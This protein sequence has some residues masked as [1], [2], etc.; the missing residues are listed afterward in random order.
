MHTVKEFFAAEI[1]QID[2]SIQQMQEAIDGSLPENKQCAYQRALL[3][4]KHRQRHL[5]ETLAA[6]AHDFRSALVACRLRLI[7][8]EET[9][10]KAASRQDARAL[11][12]ADDWWETLNDI[13]FLAHLSS[14]LQE[15]IDEQT[16]RQNFHNGKR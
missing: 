2:R 15:A 8:A 6:Q 11:L 9:H 3:D 1:H 12:H 4:N 16:P 14:Q 5:I 10:M 13:E 7:E